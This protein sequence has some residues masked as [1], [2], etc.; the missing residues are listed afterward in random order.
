M[1][2]SLKTPKRRIETPDGANFY[3]DFSN[4]LHMEKGNVSMALALNLGTTNWTVSD[5]DELAFFMPC[6]A[7]TQLAIIDPIRR[8]RI[9]QTPASAQLNLINVLLTK[10]A[11]YAYVPGLLLRGIRDEH[12]V[13]LRKGIRSVDLGAGYLFQLEDN[14]ILTYTKRGTC[15]VFSYDPVTRQTAEKRSPKRMW[16]VLFSADFL[17]EYMPP[18]TGA[19]FPSIPE[20]CEAFANAASDH[21]VSD[22]GVR[23][24]A[25]LSYLRQFEAD[26]ADVLDRL[27]ALD[28]ELQYSA[29]INEPFPSVLLLQTIFR[30]KSPN[31]IPN[32]RLMHRKVMR[33]SR[34]FELNKSF[35]KQAR[36]VN[37]G[38]FEDVRVDPAKYMNA[39]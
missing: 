1:L 25:L 13:L 39:L 4:T 16:E 20:L 12:G 36:P 7:D 23:V 18:F 19:R 8:K 24:Y 21:K 27:M 5:S 3:N 35:A 28:W 17:P 33:W 10:D 26:T 6:E 11:F 15:S 34:S 31:E 30:Y 37:S 22:V 38:M 32:T 2:Y 29:L 14:G 9:Y